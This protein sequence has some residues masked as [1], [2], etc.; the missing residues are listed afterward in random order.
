MS[1][2]QLDQNARKK[3]RLLE[4]TLT[5][6]GFG[7]GKDLKKALDLCAALSGAIAVGNPDKVGVEAWLQAFLD[8]NIP[9]QLMDLA[10]STLSI[11]F[12]LATPGSDA[13]AVP[14]HRPAL[15]AWKSSQSLLFRFG[16]Q[17]AARPPPPKD[18][19]EAVLDQLLPNDG[20]ASKQ[21][22]CQL[23]AVM[24]SLAVIV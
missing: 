17:L 1:P 5:K 24:S 19:G 21:M 7:G 12:P 2:A 3:I 11:A 15:R 23:R 6:Q 16:F 20:E 9:S 22:G 13:L 4:K 14:T 18:L 10:M 8:S